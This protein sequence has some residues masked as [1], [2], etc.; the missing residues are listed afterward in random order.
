MS[1][2]QK[3]IARIADGHALDRAEARDAFRLIMDGAAEDVE[4]AAFLM[5]LKMRGETVA[6]IAGG[7][8]VMRANALPLQA[9]PGTVDT[10]GTG[11]DGLGTYNIST[12]AAIV[13]A[14]AGVPVAKHGN[15][16]VSSLSGSSDVLAH[17][18]VAMDAPLDRVQGAL[19]RFG[20]C[21]LLAPR[22]HEA[23]RHVALV[24]KSLGVRT[25]F[26]IL[27]P[28]TNPA[29]AKR[30]LIGVYDQRWL[31]PLAETLGLLGSEHVWVVHGHDGL[32]ELSISTESSVVSFRNGKLEEMT[33]RPE[34][35]GLKRHPLEALK[36]GDAAYNAAALRDLLMGQPS[37]Y[38]DV[39]A[40]NAGAA[41]MLG[42]GAAD[43][44]AGVAMAQNAIDSGK[45]LALLNDWAAYSRGETADV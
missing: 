1:H 22:H 23:M 35:F 26:N 16:A 12:A 17:L 25:I 37:A 42:G 2:L 34:D 40:L 6:E 8:D 32:D 39:V 38:R 27:G 31:K 29:G 9:P 13:A 14:A 7:A 15:R 36:G 4:I 11:G 33:I 28:L 21:F 30:Q 10:C 3:I 24:R 18:G 41:L 5:G 44:A 43:V 20:L 19:D 45:A